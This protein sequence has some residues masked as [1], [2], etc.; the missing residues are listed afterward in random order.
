M[1][2][3]GRV[4]PSRSA[5]VFVVHQVLS[6]DVAAPHGSGLRPVPETEFEVYARVAHGCQRLRHI[7]VCSLNKSPAASRFL[8]LFPKP[9]YI[10]GHPTGLVL[11][12][13]KRSHFPAHLSNVQ[14][15][16]VIIRRA[17]RVLVHHLEVSTI[18]QLLLSFCKLPSPVWHGPAF[19]TTDGMDAA[20]VAD[21]E[22]GPKDLAP[23]S[24]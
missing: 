2:R 17:P 24:V 20:S 1:R 15:T 16:R 23:R 6:L 10:S 4:F 7:V 19:Q 14:N 3:H 22:A 11:Y 12:F 8:V 5:S 13:V 9:L 18:F 21:E